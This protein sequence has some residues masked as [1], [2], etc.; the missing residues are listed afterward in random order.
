MPILPPDVLARKM[1]EK[2]AQNTAGK[3]SVLVKELTRVIDAG[4]NPLELAAQNY[5]KMKAKLK[6]FLDSDL[7]PEIMRSVDLGLYRKIVEQ[8]T[9]SA[10]DTAVSVKKV[11]QERFADNW[12]PILVKHQAKIHAMPNVTDADRERR[13]IENLRGLKRLKGAWR[14][15]GARAT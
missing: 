8:V 4:I 5:E 12:A 3:G 13:M 9:A 2:Y 7:W 10:Y 14:R 15:G 6:A 11:K 1:K